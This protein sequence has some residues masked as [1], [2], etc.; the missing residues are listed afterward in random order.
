[1]TYAGKRV[2]RGPLRLCPDDLLPDEVGPDLQL[3]AV[4]APDLSKRLKGNPRRLKRFLNAFWLR[5]AVAE[6]RSATLQP[7]ALAKLL[8]LEELEPDAFSQVIGWLV[9]GELKEKLSELESGDDQA[10]GSSALQDW[11][12]VSPALA[13][14]DLEPYLRL[15]ASL[16][17]LATPG[18][19]L[20]SELRE[21]LGDLDAA[22]QT[23]RKAARKRLAA[24]DE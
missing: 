1:V 4:L 21:L 20:R 16:R 12:Q 17:S 9:E 14:E 18:S 7:A 10:S 11:A 15:A 13:G 6:R 8:M 19:E 22:T 2:R 24:L 3:A 5:S 23:K